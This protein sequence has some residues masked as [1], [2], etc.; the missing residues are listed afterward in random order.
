M[1]SNNV[2]VMR[3]DKVSVGVRLPLEMVNKCKQDYGNMTNAINTALE[4]MYN[5]NA[6]EVLTNCLTNTNDIQT[7]TNDNRLIDEKNIRIEELNS[8]V[9]FLKEQLGS[10]DKQIENL[11][12]AMNSQTINIHNLLTQKA[13]EAP[14]EKKWF[15]FWK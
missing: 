15:E 7:N 9:V 10:K 6:N 8:Q 3:R 1:L 2:S 13:L 12:E 11:T 5:K 14:N 4:L